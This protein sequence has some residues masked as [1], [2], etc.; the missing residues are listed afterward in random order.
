[1][2]LSTGF[3]RK[4]VV[5]IPALFMAVSVVAQ[6]PSAAQIKQFQQ[7]PKAQQ[8][9]LAKQYG[10]DISSLSSGAT[11]NRLQSDNVENL[12]PNQEL[13]A[14]SLQQALNAAQPEDK[15]EDPAVLRRF[16]ENLF[17]SQISTFAPV[18]N[19]PV[20]NS[21]TLGPDDTLLLQIYGKESSDYEL[22]VKRDGSVMLPNGGPLNVAGLSF[23]QASELIRNRISESNIGLQ[24]AVTMGQ[25]RTINIFIAGEARNP[26]MYAV[27]A[28]TSVTQALFVAGGVSEIGSLRDIRV[29]RAG[30]LIASFDLY[31]LLLHGNNAN[32]VTLQHGDVLFIAPAGAIVAIEGEVRRPAY[33]ELAKGETLEQ[34]I[35]MAGGLQAAA[36]VNAVTLHRAGPNGR[37]L[38]NLNLTEANAKN[39]MLRSGDKLLVPQLSQRVKDQVVI[40]GAVA[41]PGTYAWKQGMQLHH[42][43]GNIWSDL[44]QSTD[45]N[46]ALVVR[47]LNNRGDVEVQQFNLLDALDQSQSNQFTPLPLQPQDVVLVFHQV[48]QTYDREKLNSFVRRAVAGKLNRFTENALLAGD[49]TATLFKQLETK[50]ALIASSQFKSEQQELTEQMLLESFV[51]TMLEQLYTNPDYIALSKHF[52]RRELLF[53]L[54][55]MLTKKSSEQQA[56]PIISVSGDVKVPGEYPLAVGGNVA[57][58]ISAAGGL[59]SSAYLPRAELSRF[60]SQQVERNGVEQQNINIDL[61]AILK[62]SQQDILLTSRDRVNVFSTPDWSQVRLVNIQGEVRFPGTYQVLK[63]EKLSDV[64]KRAGG[65]TSDAYPYGAVFTR[66]AIRLRETEQA[67]KLISQLKADVASRVVSSESGLASAAGASPLAMLNELQT[68]EPIGRMVVNLEQIAKGETTYDLEVEHQDN[69]YIPRNQTSV[70]IMGEVQHPGSHRFRN[71]LSVSEYLA[72]AG[73]PRKRADQER[74]FV[75]RAD[76]SVMIP[77]QSRWFSAVNDELRPGDT[78]IMPL[79]TEYKDSL[80]VWAQVT[81]I[82]YQTAVAI[83]ALN[84]F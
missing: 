66:N 33:Y 38:V 4:L 76:G 26:G 32:D 24:A 77:S 28:L 83:A 10:I 75:I 54:L 57:M 70:T 46:Y 1:M 69:L 9:A 27:S 15:T 72:L 84:S 22:V 68:L 3:F 35:S 36:H 21:Y 14:L 74:V 29:T 34:L 40:V 19:A 5:S 62:D 79:D 50:S 55:Q 16:G 48:N 13:N 8:E 53:P 45:A 59:N 49:I 42:L 58:L 31:Q 47:R 78:I 65:F 81:Q 43:L 30:K 25:L 56:V 12:K 18:A 7:L 63:G 44:L 73:G 71:G 51:S 2:R 20:P 11:A 82:F 67:A 80:S 52:S 64:I 6:Q 39:V 17:D 23:N 60:L 61:G 41:R 37:E